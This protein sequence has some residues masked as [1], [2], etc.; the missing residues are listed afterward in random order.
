MVKFGEASVS[1][2]SRR[3]WAGWLAGCSQGLTLKRPTAIKDWKENY[4]NESPWKRAK[5]FGPEPPGNMESTSKQQSSE[6]GFVWSWWLWCNLS[7]WLEGTFITPKARAKNGRGWTIIVSGSGSYR[8]WWKCSEIML[9]RSYPPAWAME[10]DTSA[11][12]GPEV[13]QRQDLMPKPRHGQGHHHRLH[14]HCL[15]LPR[16]Q[17]SHRN[18]CLPAFPH[19]PCV[20]FFNAS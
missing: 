10:N 19:M 18:S 4:G 6:W 14:R 8:P 20:Q 15:H 9:V 7:Q 13:G 3:E 17:Y 16:G 2:Y 5:T 1:G 12:E 11:L